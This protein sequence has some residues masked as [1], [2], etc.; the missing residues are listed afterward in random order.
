MTNTTTQHPAQRLRAIRAT[1]IRIETYKTCA[2][3]HR[4][5]AK[6]AQTTVSLLAL[7]M[8]LKNF[9]DHGRNSQTGDWFSEWSRTSS[10]TLS[11]DC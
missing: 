6:S 4:C 8:E 2:L 9:M 1:G 10:G 11:W 5:V 3:D 7:K